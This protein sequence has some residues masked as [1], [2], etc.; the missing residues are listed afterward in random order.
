MSCLPGPK[1]EVQKNIRDNEKKDNNENYKLGNQ[2]QQH[3][4]QQLYGAYYQ[5]S[6]YI[7]SQE[8]NKPS[9]AYQMYIKKV[10]SEWH[11]NPNDPVAQKSRENLFYKSAK[12][13]S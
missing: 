8:T 7:P 5:D 12:L 11:R 6:K 1:K 13:N 4:A 2:R 9:R 3:K 10:K